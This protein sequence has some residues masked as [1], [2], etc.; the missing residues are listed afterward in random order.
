MCSSILHFSRTGAPRYAGLWGEAFHSLCPISIKNSNSKVIGFK[1]CSLKGGCSTRWMCQLVPTKMGGMRPKTSQS[2]DIKNKVL[3]EAISAAAAV[4]VIRTKVT[5]LHKIEG[6]NSQQRLANNKEFLSP[7]TTIVFDIE[8]T[9][10]SRENE[11]I[12]EIAF[13]DLSGGE[14][15]TFQTLVNPQRY[16]SNPR[17]HGITTHMVNRPSV[18]RMQDLIP[19]LLKYMQSRLKPGGILLLVAHNARTFDV[20][21]LISEFNRCNFVIPSSWRFV[22]TISLAREVMKMKGPKASSGLSLQ[23]LCQHYEIELGNI[24]HRAMPDVDMLSVVFQRLTLDLKMSISG[25]IERSFPHEELN[26]NKKK[27]S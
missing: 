25:A 20:P 4:N 21:F 9:G 17:F 22:D 16:V 3:M 7:V 18:P 6:C 23:A 24:S 13:R 10:L 19:I 14:N 5:E 8:T 27:K 15:S 11:R 26:T 2:S 1:T 12:I